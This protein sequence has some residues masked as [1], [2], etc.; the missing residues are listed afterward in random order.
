M[1]IITRDEAKVA[2]AKRFFTGVPCLR[3]H[4][5]ERSVANWR[6]L[7][8]AKDAAKLKYASDPEYRESQR[9]AAIVRAREKRLEDPDELRARQRVNQK[10]WLDNN[11]EELA[12]RLRAHRHAYYARHPGRAA[13]LMKEN[14][15][16]NP[17]RTRTNDNRYRA[18]K[19]SAPGQ[20]TA[21]DLKRILKQQNHKCAMPW[22]R[23]SI[24]RKMH[25][26][27]I[28]PLSGG[29][30]NNASNLQFLCPSCNS[31]K[32]ARD[33]TDFVRERGW[34]I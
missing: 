11:K 32:W 12:P 24:R 31:R 29:G 13:M 33:Q 7:E 30:T 19:K 20:H 17:E 4:I 9:A 16:A 26:D 22:C 5:S 8:C 18:R 27:H 25:L 15:C 2:G 21:E 1:E 10:R 28:V 3:G 14:R 23:K 6:C 34:L